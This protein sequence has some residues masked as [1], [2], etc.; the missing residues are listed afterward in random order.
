MPDGPHQT[1]V[2]PRPTHRRKRP[3]GRKDVSPAPWTEIV[4]EGTG[5]F[6]FDMLRYDACFPTTSEDAAAMEL[7]DASV[8][9]SERRR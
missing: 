7:I 8:D 4:V 1:H 3:Q 9:R 6:P 2:K 5:E